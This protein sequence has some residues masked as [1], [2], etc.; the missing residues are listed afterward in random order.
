MASGQ[1]SLGAIDEVVEQA[2]AVVR[3]H[4][5]AEAAHERAEE[6]AVGEED[7]PA[8]AAADVEPQLVH[9]R[10]LFRITRRW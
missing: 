5:L 6:E 10:V 1:V 2:C 7:R 3:G 8:E 4:V 9:P